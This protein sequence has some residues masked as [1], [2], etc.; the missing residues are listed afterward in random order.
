M[1]SRTVGVS[2][3][4]V[5][6]TSCV[7]VFASPYATEV[8]DYVSGTN[9]VAGYIDSATALGEPARQTADYPSGVIDVTMFNAPWQPS[10]VVSIGAGGHLIV[11]F[12]HPVTDDPGNPYG[13]DLLVFGNAS[14]GD[15]VWPIVSATTI[16][17]EPASIAVSQDG[18]VWHDIAGVWADDL[19]P[20][21]GHA[22]TSDMFG[23]DGTV[24]SDFTRPVDPSIVW[25]GKTYSEIL[26]LYDGSGGGAGVD[27]AQT[28][29]GWIQYVKVY[30]GSG[31]DFSAEIDGFADVVPEPMSI[32]LLLLG[33]SLVK[34]HRS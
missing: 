27:I 8:I 21:Q 32:L 16:Y 1:F 24:P 18:L 5:L 25:T 4:V 12:D 17:S 6:A 26:T 33:V 30:Q 3:I 22:D 19:F 13:I 31:D 28:G 9:A 20:T 11:K 15:A 10:E 2:A 14:F 34:R 23:A 7:Y 29:L